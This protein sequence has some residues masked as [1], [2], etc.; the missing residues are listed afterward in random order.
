VILAIPS[1]RQGVKHDLQNVKWRYGFI[2]YDNDGRLAIL[3]VD[4]HV[5]LSMNE[6]GVGQTFLEPP[7]AYR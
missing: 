2:D 6:S 5:Y 7:L 3:Q 4:G 1:L